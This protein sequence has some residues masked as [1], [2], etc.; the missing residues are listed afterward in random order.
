[1]LDKVIMLGIKCVFCSDIVDDNNHFEKHDIQVCWAKDASKRTFARKDLL[2]QHV[3]FAHL[4]T[5]NDYTKRGFQVPDAW[6]KVVDMAL[7]NP[8]A[9]WCGFCQRLFKNTAIR[10]DHVAQHFREGMDMS[11]WSPR[12]KD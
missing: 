3:Q 2:K 5:A 8:D 4:A 11:T 1:M 6:L 7:A 9:V 12:P 10:M